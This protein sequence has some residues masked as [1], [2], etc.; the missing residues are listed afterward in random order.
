MLLEYL[1]TPHTDAYRF[2]NVPFRARCRDL[3]SD[4]TFLVD[5]QS[6]N[7][8]WSLILPYRA[9]Y[10]R[11]DDV[12]VDTALTGGER[13]ATVDATQRTRARLSLRLCDGNETGTAETCSRR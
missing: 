5:V 4:V 6:Q 3:L 2:S 1:R 9:I 12:A 13:V 7:M 11:L 8:R 10:Q